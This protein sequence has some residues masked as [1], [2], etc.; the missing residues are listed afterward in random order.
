MN[1]TNRNIT[2]QQFLDKYINTIKSKAPVN[3]GALKNSITSNISNTSTSTEIDIEGLNYGKYQDLGVNGTKKNWNSPFSFNK[4]PN[5]SSMNLANSFPV[6]KSI[7]ENGI[8]PTLFISQDLDN[9]V[10]TFADDYVNAL[11]D[12][13]VNNNK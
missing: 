4:M 10:D 8:K 9:Q 2:I 3:T 13:F 6:A 7:M 5:L 1:N 12:D 11:W